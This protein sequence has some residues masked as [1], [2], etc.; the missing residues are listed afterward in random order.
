MDLQLF[1]IFLALE[2]LAIDKDTNDIWMIGDTK[3]DLISAK[4]AGIESIGVLSGYGT[5]EELEQF[6]NKICQDALEAVEFLQK[7]L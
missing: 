3:L 2:K 4:N 7:G 1:I 6:T 5:K